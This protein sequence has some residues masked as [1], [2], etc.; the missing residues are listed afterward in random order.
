MSQYR[1]Q[2]VCSNVIA[3]IS[4]LTV[5]PDRPGENA[6]LEAALF[7]DEQRVFFGDVAMFKPV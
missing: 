6:H 2:L 5:S 3:M 4:F 1:P 7:V